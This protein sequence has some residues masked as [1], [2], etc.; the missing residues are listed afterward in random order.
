[1]LI[2][3]HRQQGLTLVELMIAA[4]ISLMV[5]A[6]VVTVYG[7]ATSHSA[8]QL[9]QAHLHRQLHGLMHVMASDLT[10]AGFWQFDPARHSPAVN[11][12]QDATTLIRTGHYRNEPPGSCIL[13]AYD[14]DRDGQLGVGQCSGGCPPQR[15]DDNVEQFGYRLNRGRVQSRYG[16]GGFGCSSGFWQAVTDPDIEIARLR[17][18]LQQSCSNLLEPGQPCVKHQARLFQHHVKIEL[19]G[20]LREHPATRLQLS[21]WLRVRNDQLRKGDRV[22]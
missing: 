5:L 17:L 15:D 6:G 20:H 12:F 13:F 10:R 9:R 21:R 3:R 2:A 18:T 22:P 11:P 8:R 1:V 19:D 14:L 7:A 4:A 16:G